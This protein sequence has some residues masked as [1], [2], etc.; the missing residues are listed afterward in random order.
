[1]PLVAPAGCWRPSSGG[2]VLQFSGAASSRFPLLP[3]HITCSACRVCRLPLERIRA[4]AYRAHSGGP[5][6]PHL[7]IYTLISFA[8]TLFLARSHLSAP[9][10]RAGYLWG[11]PLG[12]LCPMPGSAVIGKNSFTRPSSVCSVS[13]MCNNVK[14]ASQVI[15]C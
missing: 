14:I 10:T 4:V 11:L 9:R 8:S 7:R 1:M 2:C 3:L 12:L 6:P 15:Q 5:G 13:I